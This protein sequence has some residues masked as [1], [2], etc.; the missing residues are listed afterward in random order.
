MSPLDIRS[1]HFKGELRDAE[2]HRARL[3]LRDEDVKELRR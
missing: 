2:G 1:A 3:L